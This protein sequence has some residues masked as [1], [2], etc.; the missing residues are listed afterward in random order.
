MQTRANARTDVNVREQLTKL[1][2]SGRKELIE[3]MSGSNEC[4]QSR[5]LLRNIS[6]EELRQGIANGKDEKRDGSKDRNLEPSGAGES[7]RVC[8]RYKDDYHS[9][10]AG[11][12]L[13]EKTT[14]DGTFRA[15]SNIQT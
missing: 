11:G 3:G 7:T 8:D 12:A 15:M 14:Q 6:R 10:Q 9:I 2:A 5:A 4:D 13:I 1:E